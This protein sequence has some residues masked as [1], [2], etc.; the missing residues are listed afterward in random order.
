MA[1]SEKMSSFQKWLIGVILILGLLVI[2]FWRSD[3]EYNRCIK[4]PGASFSVG[5]VQSF[6]AWQWCQKSFLNPF[7]E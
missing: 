3:V 2:Y 6:R 1:G 5:Q 7:G 4:K